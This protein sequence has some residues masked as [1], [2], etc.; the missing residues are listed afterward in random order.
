MALRNRHVTG[1]TG[2]VGFDT[3]FVHVECSPDM[4][5]VA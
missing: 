5:A 4:E 3:E 1:G 2:D